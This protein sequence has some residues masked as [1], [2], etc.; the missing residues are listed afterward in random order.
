M[1]L[2]LLTSTPRHL[3]ILRSS[4]LA[5]PF[6]D[7]SDYNHHYTLEIRYILFSLY[8][9]LLQQNRM[10]SGSQNKNQRLVFP[11]FLSPN[12]C[13]YAAKF[14]WNPQP[15]ITPHPREG[16]RPL[17]WLMDW[18]WTRIQY[19]IL[20]ATT[21]HLH[22]FNFSSEGEI[23]ESVSSNSIQCLLRPLW[24]RTTLLLS[25]A[26]GSVESSLIP[27]LGVSQTIPTHNNLC[28]EMSLS[29]MGYQ[30]Q[31]LGVLGKGK[32]LS[33]SPQSSAHCY[34]GEGVWGT[35]V[36]CCGWY[37]L[38]QGS[39]PHCHQTGSWDSSQMHCWEWSLMP[40]GQERPVDPHPDCS[41]PCSEPFLWGSWFQKS[42]VDTVSVLRGAPGTSAHGWLLSESLFFLFFFF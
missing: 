6:T 12:R 4:S 24:P 7:N 29:G 37:R 35:S 23:S 1:V 26:E 34:G 8:C 22:V 17:F 13:Y 32:P 40:W 41:G 2:L 27:A 30:G 20:L 42:I 3:S 11:Y 15:L 21:A 28:V 18:H 39:S 5:Q 25:R 16:T 9:Y 10:S 33:P 19:H 38:C 31:C 36:H 14:R